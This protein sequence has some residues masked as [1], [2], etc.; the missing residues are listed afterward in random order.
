ML[1][2]KG[3]I[4]MQVAKISKWGNSQGVRIPKD[5]LRQIGIESNE[6]A[7][8]NISVDDGKLIIEK[9]KEESKL[10]RRFE[11]YDFNK[12]LNDNSRVADF[13]RPVGKELW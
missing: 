11:N 12:Y 6:D 4:A 1:W 10:M 9:S 3:G 5:I 8:V 7:K 13:G 2:S